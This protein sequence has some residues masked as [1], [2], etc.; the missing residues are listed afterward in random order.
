M[1]STKLLVPYE[2]SETVGIAP[3]PRYSEQTSV[4]FV[5]FYTMKRFHEEVKFTP[6]LTPV[7][8]SDSIIIFDKDSTRKQY[9]SETYYEPRVKPRKFSDTVIVFPKIPQQGYVTLLDYHIDE[10]RKW[11]KTTMEFKGMTYTTKKFIIGEDDKAS[12]RDV[13]DNISSVP[14]GPGASQIYL[15]RW[16]KDGRE[17]SQG[18]TSQYQVVDARILV[19]GY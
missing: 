8:Y 7:G 11:F 4:S 14:T 5:D 9:K 6:Y 3:L 2:V 13:N 19:N 12:E 10:C 18:K 1:R 16:E 17:E 15:P